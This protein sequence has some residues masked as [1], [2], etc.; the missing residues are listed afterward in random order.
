[1]LQWRISERSLFA[2][3]N[4]LSGKQPKTVEGSWT[5][6]TP[7]ISYFFSFLDGIKSTSVLMAHSKESCSGR[8]ADFYSNRTRHQPGFL[9]SSCP[10]VIHHIMRIDS[11]RFSRLWQWGSQRLLLVGISENSRDILICSLFHSVW[12]QLEWKHKFREMEKELP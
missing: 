8:H 7:L 6:L 11:K 5:E 9:A 4:Y 3:A 2:Q 1:M 12:E 10:A